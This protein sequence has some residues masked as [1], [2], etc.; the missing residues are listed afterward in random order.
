MHKNLPV[1][2][3]FGLFV[4][5][6]FAIIALLATEVGF[7]LSSKY[8][9]TGVAYFENE[10]WRWNP[11]F[12]FTDKDEN[13]KPFTIQINRRGFRDENHR[14]NK[15]NDET[16]ILVIG[17]SYTAALYLPLENRY[18]NMVEDGLNKTGKQKKIEVI[19]AGVPAWGTDQHYLYLL[20]EGLKLQPDYVFV[21]VCP[22]DV[23]E[24]YCKKII[25]QNADGS[26][27]FNRPNFSQDELKYW[28]WSNISCIYQ[29]LQ[30][31]KYHTTYGSFSDLMS[32]FK[33]NFGQEDSTDWDRPVF[34]K[35][36]FEDLARARLLYKTLLTEM[37]NQCEA[38]KAKFAVAVIPLPFELDTAQTDTAI[39]PGLLNEQTRQ[40]AAEKHFG[41]IDLYTPATKEK[42]P[43]KL[44][45]KGDP[46]FSK[47]GNAFA[48]THILS[49]YSTLIK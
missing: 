47:Y 12:S 43:Q 42:E 6:L 20:N 49:Y 4:I 5:A 10:I 31:E 45:L 23:R 14:V 28:K 27:K 16:R 3:V 21:L 33:F 8:W 19:N 30:A 13:G 11:W 15:P 35:T 18:T 48:A 36:E 1:K 22:N 7:R 2:I 37:N 39:A 40:L 44:F 25:E 41:F 26:L 32:H 34:L 24:A 17:D 38:H 9:L 46:H 29:Y